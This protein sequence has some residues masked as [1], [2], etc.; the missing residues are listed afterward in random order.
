MGRSFLSYCR[1]LLIP[2]SVI[3]FF[4]I[5]IRNIFY[6]ACIFREHRLNVKVISVGNITWG[7]TGKT[8]LV[9]YMLQAMLKRGLK[10]ALLTRDYGN[11]EEK[12]L[13]RS[14]SGVPVLAGKDR[15]K[16]GRE[17]V[18]KYSVDTILL[19]D[20]FQYRALKRDLDVVC[21]DATNP[22]GNGWVIPAGSMRESISGLKRGDVFL[23]TKVDLVEDQKSL[24]E[25]EVKLK[26]INP[27]AL[28]VKS[29]HRARHFYRLLDEVIV[30]PEQL[31]GKNIAL[32]SGIGNPSSFEKTILKLGLNVKKHFMFRDHYWYK[33]KDLEKIAG[34]C[35]QNEIDAIITTEKDAV[36]LRGSKDVIGVAELIVL[37]IELRIV[38]NEQAFFNRLF[39]IYN[40]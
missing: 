26:K 39:G 19:D 14:A 16:T 21:I 13:S 25:L 36:R 7:G 30:D 10:V 23:I 17:A 28:L 24:F 37:G 27:N 12:L 29:I 35:K 18:T 4:I 8:P 2:F 5:A 15:V 22:F 40:T 11:D 9:L 1:Y 38:E 32:L 34:Y 6:R 20:G 3:Y 33:E 31:K